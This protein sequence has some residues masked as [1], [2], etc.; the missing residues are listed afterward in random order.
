MLCQ[1][2]FSKNNAWKCRGTIHVGQLR[3][4]DEG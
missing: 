1:E 2:G 3:K 4:R